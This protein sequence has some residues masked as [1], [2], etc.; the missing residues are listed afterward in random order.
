MADDPYEDPYD[1]AGET[2]AAK[3]DWVRFC[4][5]VEA[6]AARIVSGPLHRLTHSAKRLVEL[7][8]SALRMVY[9]EEEEEEG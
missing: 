2:A 1:G 3:E 6:N 7:E 4:V 5:R 9:N 8:E